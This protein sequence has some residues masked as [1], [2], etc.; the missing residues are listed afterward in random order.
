MNMPIKI[1]AIQRAQPGIA[2]GGAK[3][4]YATPVM[5]GEWNLDSMTKAIEKICTVSGADIRA[6]LYAM[7]DVAIDGLGDSKIIR[8]GDLGSIRVTLSSNGVE[9]E[10]DVNSA[11]I[12]KAGVIFTPGPRIKLTMDSVKYTKV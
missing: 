11:I 7:V 8:L 4:Y 6:V 2:G 10:K 3:K 9:L 1:K 12:R 5:D